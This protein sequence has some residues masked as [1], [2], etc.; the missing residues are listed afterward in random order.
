MEGGCSLMGDLRIAPRPDRSPLVSAPVITAEIVDVA[1]IQRRTLRL[2][3]TTQII[4]GIGTTIGITVGALLAARLAGVALSGVAQSS[5]VVGGA[6]LA[7]PA[8][9]MMRLHGRRPGLVLA[10]ACGA[11]GAV[12]V[13]VAAVTKLI[14]LLFVG[15]FFFGGGTTA[16]LQARYT[17]VDLAEPSRRGR[18]L[19]VIVWAS[20][21]GAVSAPNLAAF[22]DKALAGWHLP[23]LTGPFVVSSV[24]FVLNA[25]AMITLLRPDPLLTAN[26]LAPAVE[27]S[28]PRVGL[29]AAA[30]IVWTNPRAR[31]GVCA[32]A[33]GHLVMI[34]VMSMTPV[35]LV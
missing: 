24:A 27:A 30:G 32:V 17:A 35:L 19:S 20:T 34:G 6:L 1:A 23:E 7:I 18:Q 28:A 16:N 3:F 10:Y 4:G 13:I 15:M 14:P 11:V 9:R 31:L 29:R 2:L 25:I 33:V 8:T 5:A 22:A 26:S 12:L 21:L